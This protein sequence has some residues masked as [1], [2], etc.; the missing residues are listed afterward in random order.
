MSNVQALLAFTH[1]LKPITISINLR[2]PVTAD[3]DNMDRLTLR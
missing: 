3:I 1:I 2:H